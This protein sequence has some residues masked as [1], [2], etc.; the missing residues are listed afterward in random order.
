[1][2][3]IYCISIFL[4]LCA[5]GMLYYLIMV[6]D[7]IPVH[8]LHKF[9]QSDVGMTIMECSVCR[10]SI[11]TDDPNYTQALKEPCPGK[12]EENFIGD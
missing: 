2:V 1:M 10:Y 5:I 7:T 6:E 12:T 4:S 11:E 9:V 3:L 8:K